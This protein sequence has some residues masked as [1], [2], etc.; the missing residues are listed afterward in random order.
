MIG[1]I[2][3][4][5]HGTQWTTEKPKSSHRE[6]QN[7]SFRQPLPFPLASAVGYWVPVLRPWQHVCCPLKW[8]LLGKPVTR[9]HTWSYENLEDALVFSKIHFV[10]AIQE[11]RRKWRIL[12]NDGRLEKIRALFNFSTAWVFIKAFCWNKSSIYF[13]GCH[14]GYVADSRARV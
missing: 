10:H 8:H 11:F 7:P 4:W 13:T 3:S 5:N 9:Q 6:V 14:Y 2:D 1:N 12:K